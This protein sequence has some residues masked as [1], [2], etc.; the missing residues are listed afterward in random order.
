VSPTVTCRTSRSSAWR[1]GAIAAIVAAGAS[2]RLGGQPRPAFRADTWLVVLHAVATTSRGA[3]VTDL[4]QRAITVYENGKTQPIKVFRKEDI[5]VSLGLV[6]DNSGSMRT[7]R[8]AVSDAAR[9]FVGA[10]NSL[11]EIFVINFADAPHLAVPLTGDG[12]VLDAGLTAID[13][14]GGTAVRDAIIAAEEYL[15]GHARHDR[16]ILLVITD[17]HDNASAASGADLRKAVDQATDTTI[18]AVGLRRDAPAGPARRRHELEDV[19][20]R[21]GGSVFWA[22]S[23][24]EIGAIV[25]DI[26]RAIR[27]QYTIAYAPLNQALDGTYR[28]VRVKVAP[29]GRL[30]IRTRTGYRATPASVR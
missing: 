18:F 9:T 23:G 6:I 22:R 4:Q 17:G 29:S 19:A 1:V 5:P 26:A 3:L 15:R 28:T 7:L 24:D 27:Q 13:S 14:V 2:A 10:S 12:R 8:A 25:L 30:R 21:T 11:D 20:E 16:K